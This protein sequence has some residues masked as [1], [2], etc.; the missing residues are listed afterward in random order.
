MSSGG[1]GVTL[2]RAVVVVK[3]VVFGGCAA[4]APC[5]AEGGSRSRVVGMGWL[6]RGWWRCRRPVA[7]EAKPPPH[8]CTVTSL[9]VTNT[10]SSSA[11]SSEARILPAV[12]LFVQKH[13]LTTRPLARSE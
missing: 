8:V 13:L 4:Q 9:L 5:R 2:A 7:L 11:L 3:A 6:R 10:N 12:V 1:S